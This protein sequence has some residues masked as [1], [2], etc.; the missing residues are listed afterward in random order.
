LNPRPH[1]RAL[2]RR[3][4]VLG[5]GAA[6][7]FVV[8]QQLVWPTPQVVFAQGDSSGWMELP[9]AGGLIDLP[10]RI[11]GVAV[12]AVVDSGAQYSAIDAGL[13]RRLALPAATPIPLVAFGVSGGPSLTHAVNLDVDLGAFAVKGLRA[14][15]LQLRPLSGLTRQP[16][17][18]LLGRDFLRAATMEVDFPRARAA[19]FAPGV[20]RPPA[21]ARITAVRNRSGGLMVPVQ[22]EAAPPVEV[23]LDTGATGALA[24]SEK[25]AMASGLLDGRP[26]RTGESVTLGGVSE[27]GMVTARE[28]MFAGSRLKNVEVQIYRPAPSAPAPDGLLGLGVLQRFHFALDLAGERLFLIG[29]E[30]PPPTAPHGPTTRFEDSA[31]ELAQ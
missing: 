5:A 20:W 12:H 27:D 14:A 30:R 16:F 28:V 23:M 3:L 21:D 11:R 22:V 13:A 10:A 29:P 25:T 19:F 1:R 26:L 6:G 4:V 9:A 17:S 24:L 18:L 31:A 7:Y 8:R 2:L 15:S